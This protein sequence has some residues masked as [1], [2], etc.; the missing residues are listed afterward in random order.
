MLLREEAVAAAVDTRAAGAEMTGRLRLT[1]IEAGGDYAAVTAEAVLQDAGQGHVSDS[2]MPILLTRGEAQAVA[3]RWLA[4]AQ[5]SKDMARFAL[6]PSRSGLGPGDVLR[7]RQKDGAS[8]C[9]RIDRVERAGAILIEAV[10]VEAGVYL[11]AEIPAEDPAIRPFIAPVPVLP[12]MM[13]LPLMRGDEV[14]HAPYL[15][16]AARP[17]PGPVAAYMSV[18]QEGGFDLNLT[19]RK[20]AVVGRT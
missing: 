13:D 11:P 20:G 19:L 9:W 2:E 5:V 1:H 12:I 18:E 3:G 8:Q 16:V 14:P 17:W 4:E 6:P 7:V 10:R 15:A